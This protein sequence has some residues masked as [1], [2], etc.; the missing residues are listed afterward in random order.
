[1]Y[2][3]RIVDKILK[4]KLAGAGAV[5]GKETKEVEKFILFPYLLDCEL[6]VIKT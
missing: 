2:K 6:K 5:R 3:P 1:M 4:R